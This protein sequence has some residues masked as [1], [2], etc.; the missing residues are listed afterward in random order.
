MV[1]SAARICVSALHERSNSRASS[2]IA[3]GGS[4]TQNSGF[5]SWDP[6]RTNIETVRS[7][8]W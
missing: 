7:I 2:K 6:T 1:M 4:K 8:L 5:W 3:L